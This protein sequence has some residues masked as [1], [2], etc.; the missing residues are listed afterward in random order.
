MYD[1][2][3]NKVIFNDLTN[4]NLY[5]LS[6]KLI[7]QLIYETGGINELDAHIYFDKFAHFLTA[8]QAIFDI[9]MIGEYELFRSRWDIDAEIE[10]RIDAEM[11]FLD[12]YDENVAKVRMKANNLTEE[13]FT[14]S[15]YKIDNFYNYNF[16]RI[17]NIALESNGFANYEEV[18]TQ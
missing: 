4:D 8:E 13:E 12:F 1:I 17:I 7:A 16:E 2:Y 11:R 6:N 15:F 5:S 14:E 3:D 18:I 10:S 9:I